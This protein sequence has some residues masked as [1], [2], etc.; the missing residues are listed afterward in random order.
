MSFTT[1]TPQNTLQILPGGES[2]CAS[3]NPVLLLTVGHKSLLQGQGVN[4]VLLA[5]PCLL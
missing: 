2:A 1:F 3:T 5:M 4:F